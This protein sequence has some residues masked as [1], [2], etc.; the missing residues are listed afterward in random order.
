A[1]LAAIVRIAHVDVEIR[2]GCKKLLQVTQTCPKG[3]VETKA[4]KSYGGDDR[5]FHNESK[6]NKF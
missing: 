1:L 6:L 5:K 2:N 4:P 3:V